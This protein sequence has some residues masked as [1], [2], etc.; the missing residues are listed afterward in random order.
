[1]STSESTTVVALDGLIYIAGPMSPSSFGLDETPPD[2]DWNH[3]QFN[4]VAE[5]LTAEGH[6]VINPAALDAE[7]G[8]TGL[9]AWDFYLRRDIK[10]LADCTGIVMLPGWRGSKGARLEHHIATELDMTITY[11]ED[12]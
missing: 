10:V 3:P 8:D 1:M 7:A 5:Q 6:A 4:A 12:A 2:W 11:L 9:E